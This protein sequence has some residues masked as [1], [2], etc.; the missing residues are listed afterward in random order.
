MRIGIDARSLA[1]WRG[2]GVYLRQLF[3]HFTA[4]DHE[5]L[6]FYDASLQQPEDW[7]DRVSWFPLKLACGSAFVREEWQLP[8]QYQAHTL[9]AF[10]HPD[11]NFCLHRGSRAIV[12]VHDMIVEKFPQYFFGDHPWRRFKGEGAHWLKRWLI[13][14]Q[15]SHI[16]TVSESSKRDIVDLVGV[17]PERVSVVYNGVSPMFRPLQDP[18][19]AARVGRRYGFLGP[20]LLYA[21]GLNPHKNLGRLVDAYALLKQQGFPHRLLLAGKKHDPLNKYI[22]SSYQELIQ[23]CRRH[24]LES[25]VLFLDYVPP[26]FRLVEL[27]NGADL[28]VFPSLYE[29]F[30]LPA[31]EA[32]AC[33][34]PVVTSNLSSLPEVVGDS[35][36]KVDPTSVTELAGAMHRLLVDQ[37]L[38]RECVEAG[39]LR[40]RRFSWKDA[41]ART[42][43]ILEGKTAH[44]L[45]E[46][47]R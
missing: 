3:E 22:L 24:G 7:G 29:G 2:F 6:L 44:S 38:R 45:L 18:G 4:T 17:A 46:F 15:A 19:V 20:Y 40:A 12:T 11:N 26:D 14:R 31:A 33:G 13:R 25:E 36:L 32:L 16:I 27:I 39:L 41:A 43:S 9:D 23:R 21:G 37:D 42:L 28:F 1:N 47:V 5:W 30:G 35:A 10:F 8:R 34:T